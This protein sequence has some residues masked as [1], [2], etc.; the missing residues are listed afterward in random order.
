MISSAQIRAA[1]SLLDW[2]QQELARKSGLSLR[3]LNSIEREMATPRAGNLELIV[4]TLVQAGIE[5]SEFDGVR[6]KTERLEV[7]KFEGAHYVDQHMLDI[8]H[9]TRTPGSEILYSIQREEDFGG[10]R[11]S[12]V[13]EY[14]RH[15]V[16]HDITERLMI[17]RGETYVIS[18]PWRYRWFRRDLFSHVAYIVYADNVAFQLFNSPQRMIIIRN[19]GI[20]DMFRRQFEANWAMAETPWFASQYEVPDREKPWSS[21]KAERARAWI[22]SSK[23]KPR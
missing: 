22:E 10:M 18:P 9:E 19:P 8:M 15:L 4:Q 3:A 7:V 12:V 20:A 13:D 16:Q 17:A 14:F 23:R 5:F 11:P 1:R 21:A 6:R 2:T